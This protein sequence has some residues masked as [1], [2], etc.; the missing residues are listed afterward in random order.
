M[1]RDLFSPPDLAA[2]PAWG[3]QVNFSLVLPKARNGT[4]LSEVRSDMSKL[5]VV[6]SA[7]ST[8]GEVRWVVFCGLVCTDPNL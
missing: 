4:F 8:A 7:C 3:I 2:L 1:F 5:P 6:L